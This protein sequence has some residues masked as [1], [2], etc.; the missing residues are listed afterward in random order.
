M[1]VLQ[2]YLELKEFLETM[3]P[4]VVVWSEIG[5]QVAPA[6]QCP[7]RIKVFAALDIVLLL[8]NQKLL[9][10]FRKKFLHFYTI[11]SSPSAKLSFMH[12]F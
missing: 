11:T 9:P 2:H 8:F 5:A 10:I 4:T 3:P 1:A 12:Q 7:C 6:F